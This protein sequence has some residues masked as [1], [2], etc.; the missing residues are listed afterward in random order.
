MQLMHRARGF[1]LTELAVVLMVVALVL[2]GA[3]MTFSA[4]VEQRNLAEVQRRLDLAAEAVHAFA[5]VNRR[6]PCPARRTSSASHSQGLESFCTTSSGTCAGA[7]TLTVQGHGNCSNFHDGYLPA[8]ALG[9]TPTDSDGFAVDVW[10]NR[11]RYAVAR[12]VTA[13]AVTPPAGTRVFT[14]QANLQTY[15]IT[16]RP[17]DLDVCTSAACTSRVIST[18]TALLIV[19]STGQNGNNTA[20]YGSDETENTDGDAVFVSRTLAS[21]Q[22]SGGTFDDLVTFVPVGM[23]YGKLLAAGILP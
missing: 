10:G 9:V 6:L 3:M 4:Q 8:V 2:G 18:Q 21:A 14:S 15:G 12:D 13:C 22:S 7:E 23:V 17:N 1:T 19:Y 16:C 5:I 11:L 20:G